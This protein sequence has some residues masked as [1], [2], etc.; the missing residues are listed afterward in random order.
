M[1]LLITTKITFI[2]QQQKKMPFVDKSMKKQ[3]FSV[4]TKEHFPL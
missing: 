4:K 2:S 1:Q 3:I